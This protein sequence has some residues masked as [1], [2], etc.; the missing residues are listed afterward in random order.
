MISLVPFRHS[1]IKLILTSAPFGASNQVIWLPAK[2]A[3]YYILVSVN[4]KS[5]KP[6]LQKRHVNLACTVDSQYIS[7]ADNCKPRN[8]VILNQL[9]DKSTLPII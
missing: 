9:A 4:G 8:L 6:G 1:T 2:V 3:K 5:Q 7:S